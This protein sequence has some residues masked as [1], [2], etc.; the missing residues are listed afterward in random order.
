MNAKRIVL[1]G[2][3][4]FV[5]MLLLALVFHTSVEAFLEAA[6]SN[7]LRPDT[8]SFGIVLATLSLLS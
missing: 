8:D 7:I 6:Y 1:A 4:G 3:A 2:L 5:A